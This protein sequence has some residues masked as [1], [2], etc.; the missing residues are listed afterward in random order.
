MIMKKTN[1]NNS[2]ENN[3]SLLT[4]RQD[5]VR[6]ERSECSCPPSSG[7]DQIF[8]E[9][10]VLSNEEKDSVIQEMRQFFPDMKRDQFVFDKTDL[11]PKTERVV[12]FVSDLAQQTC[13]E[14][15]A[16]TELSPSFGSDIF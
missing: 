15:E 8:I 14:G 2:T 10:V 9:G 4:E 11:S 5:V 12:K 6:N 1:T 16:V 7:S 13:S 3:N